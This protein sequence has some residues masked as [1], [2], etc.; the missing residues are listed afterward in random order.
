LFVILRRRPLRL[1]SH[2]EDEVEEKWNKKWMKAVEASFA[3][4]RS[5]WV[6]MEIY[7]DYGGFKAITSRRAPIESQYQVWST[8]SNLFF[9]HFRLL[10]LLFIT[11]S[12]KS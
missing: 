10:L 9:E 3:F 6:K 2:F 7:L 1:E 8:K 5:Y 11:E 4:Q 12:C